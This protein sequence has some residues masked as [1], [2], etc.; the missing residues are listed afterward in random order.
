[1]GYYRTY[2]TEILCIIL[3]RIMIVKIHLLCMYITITSLV[4]AARAET[5]I[6]LS[7]LSVLRLLIFK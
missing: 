4:M 3:H 7:T 5:M 1:M 2:V 6:D